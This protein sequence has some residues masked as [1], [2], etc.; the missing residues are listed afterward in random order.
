MF[1]SFSV[2]TKMWSCLVYFK[3]ACRND[4]SQ[5]EKDLEKE[6]ISAQNPPDLRVKDYITVQHILILTQN[7]SSEKR[8]QFILENMDKNPELMT[9]PLDV[10]TFEILWP[11]VSERLLASEDMSA[12][13]FM[14]NTLIT[15]ID[16][17]RHFAQNYAAPFVRTVLAKVDTEEGKHMSSYLLKMASWFV[18][19][20]VE[21]TEQIRDQNQILKK[22]VSL[23]I[24]RDPNLY[25]PATHKFNAY[26]LYTHNSQVIK[27]FLHDKYNI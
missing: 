27:Q 8:K 3:I 21:T 7:Y 13:K 4:A 16:L 20:V 24:E 12:K 18:S 15:E 26:D 14:I 9:L 5:C 19:L 6:G 1:Y 22:E 25:R 10:N 11:D 2:S 23:K 17:N